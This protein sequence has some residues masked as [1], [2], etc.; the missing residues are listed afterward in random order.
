MATFSFLHGRQ[1][2]GQAG[3]G[4]RAL[5]CGGA[6]LAVLLLSAC[7]TDVAVEV[8]NRQAAQELARQSQYGSV[9]AGWR[10]FQNKCA[11]CHGPAATGG[12]GGPNLLPRVDEMGPRQFVSLVLKRYDWN[13][14]IDK[15]KTENSTREALITDI[16]QRKEAA[17]VMP[18]WQGEPSVSTHI[19]DLYAYL[20]ARAQGAQGPNR[21]E[22]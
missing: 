17:L 22:P 9:Y 16:L 12:A 1:P 6:V 15:A 3:G 18:A 2:F 8:Q 4:V 7:T 20:S 19:G 14:S 5:V 13:N 10:I 21:P 11:T